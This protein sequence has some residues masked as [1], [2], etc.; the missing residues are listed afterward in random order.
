MVCDGKVMAVV[1]LTKKLENII[2]FLVL[3]LNLVNS[4]LQVRCRVTL[5]PVQVSCLL[6]YLVRCQ[7]V[8]TPCS[9]YFAAAGL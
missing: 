2:L 5:V 1:M 7:A 4:V 8:S 6:C 9:R 3:D